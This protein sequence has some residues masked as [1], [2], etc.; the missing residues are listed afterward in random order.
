MAVGHYDVTRTRLARSSSGNSRRRTQ[1]L[2]LRAGP[3]VLDLAFRWHRPARRDDGRRAAIGRWHRG[4]ASAWRSSVGGSP[5][6]T[7]AFSGREQPRARNAGRPIGRSD[8]RKRPTVSCRTTW[9][10]LPIAQQQVRTHGCLPEAAEAAKKQRR[11]GG[12]G[13]DG[14][15]APTPLCGQSARRSCPQPRHQGGR[16]KPLALRGGCSS[17]DRADSLTTRLL[18]GRPDGCRAAARA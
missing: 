13:A 15:P 3:M 9:P 10:P 7:G 4:A 8:S 2:S 18:A 14:P 11:L 12:G 16:R 5:T 17:F 6:A 1:H